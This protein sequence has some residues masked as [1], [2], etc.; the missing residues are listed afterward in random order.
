MHCVPKSPL[1]LMT[2]TKLMQM[3]IGDYYIGFNCT[4]ISVGFEQE[5]YTVFE[6]VAASGE[7]IL[8]P[9]IKE[10]GQESELTFEVIAILTL[11]SGPTAAQPDE[12]FDASPVIRQDFDPDVQEIDYRFELFDD[13]PE[14]PDVPEPTET[15]QIQLVLSSEGFANVNLGGSSL[16][17]TA[18]IVIIDDDG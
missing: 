2:P 1:T 7:L 18:T 15:F 9:I 4:A 11:G 3:C 13:T 5:R 6:A 8:I 16:F 14:N 10:N 17:A 12:D